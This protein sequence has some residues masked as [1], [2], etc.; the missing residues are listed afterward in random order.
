MDREFDLLNDPVKDI[1]AGHEFTGTVRPPTTE[2][3][4]KVDEWSRLNARDIIDEF[5]LEDA[6]GW[7]A[8]DKDGNTLPHYEV[9]DPECLAADAVSACFE[10]EP[11]LEPHCNDAVKRSWFQDLVDSPEFNEL[12]AITAGHT[13]SSQLAAAQI[14]R[15][16][17]GYRTVITE[18]EEKEAQDS[19]NE[20]TGSEEGSKE[21]LESVIKRKASIKGAIEQAENDIQDA[22]DAAE[23]LGWSSG[24]SSGKSKQLGQDV[25]GAFKA[26]RDNPDFRSIS[27]W[28]GRFRRLAQSLQ[29][30][31]FVHGMDDL[32][33]VTLGSQLNQLVTSELLKMAHPDLEWDLMERLAQHRAMVKEYRAT[34]SVGRGPIMVLVDESGSMYQ[35]G[36]ITAAKGFALSLAWLA[37]HQNR[38]CCLVGWAGTNEQRVLVLD[39]STPNSELLEWTLSFLGGNTDPPLHMIPEL[40]RRTKAPEGK[41]DIIW[42]TDGECW[43]QDQV[44]DDFNE[45]REEHKC[46]VWTIG[47][48]TEAGS[49]SDF[50]DKRV[51]VSELS[52]DAP[53][54]KEILSI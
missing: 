34:E 27:N 1:K 30:R 26:L 25:L 13:D 43:I 49:F 52:T 54:I 4:V 12:H 44:I 28:A 3:A 8:K 32:V 46:K 39:P 24:D 53:V 23:S 17:Q 11:Q 37:R 16:Y 35:D 10:Y 22:Q 6:P 20:G 7:S 19:S 21:S 15:Q 41:T 40:Y 51:S 48:G 50:T 45:W 38:W 2:H 42:I 9:E 29:S 33:G 5:D 36:K 14:Y 47:I 18:E 31:K